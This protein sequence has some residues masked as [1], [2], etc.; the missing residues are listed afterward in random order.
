MASPNLPPAP[1][2]ASITA[3]LP[4]PEYVDIPKNSREILRVQRE[5]YMGHDMLNLR[6]WYGDGTGEY[7]PGKQGVAVKAALIP[8]LIEALGTVSQTVGEVAV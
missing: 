4:M 5:N 6:V 7:R 8:E 2:Q 1:L 3:V